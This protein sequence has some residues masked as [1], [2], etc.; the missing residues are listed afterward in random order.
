[1]I[2]SVT[3]S[4]PDCATLRGIH[5]FELQSSAIH[6]TLF[7]TGEGNYYTF[8]CPTCYAEV[9]KP[10]DETIQGLLLGYVNST[11]VHVPEELLDGDRTGP[12]LTTEDLMDFM[13]DLHGQ[14]WRVPDHIYFDAAKKVRENA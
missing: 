7:D 10:A 8:F 3:V 12:V 9:N 2:V 13:I 14:D 4:C 11:L 6:M 1:M 5:H